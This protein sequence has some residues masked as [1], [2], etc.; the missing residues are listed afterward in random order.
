MNRNVLKYYK[1]QNRTDPSKQ[2]YFV[3]SQEIKNSL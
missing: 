2:T 3:H 1:V